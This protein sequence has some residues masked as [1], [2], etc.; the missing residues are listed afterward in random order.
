[1]RIPQ[2][3]SGE[4]GG[5]EAHVAGE[6]DPCP[7]AAVAPGVAL[8][9]EQREI[10]LLHRVRPQPD[11]QLDRQPARAVTVRAQRGV[12]LCALGR[13]VRI[14]ELG[15]GA[16]QREVGGVRG[17]RAVRGAVELQIAADDPAVRFR[18]VLRLRHGGWRE[19]RGRPQ[20]VVVLRVRADVR[21][22]LK[23]PP[24]ARGVHALVR[25]DRWV[26]ALDPER[27]IDDPNAVFP[28]ACHLGPV[29]VDDVKV[30]RAVRSAGGGERRLAQPGRVAPAAG[31]RGGVPARAGAGR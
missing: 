30:L 11:E 2:A 12:V 29:A 24:R 18:A 21:R 31:R 26:Q 1:M 19:P 28:S 27:L 9:L 15:V 25:L 14:S 20:R 17:P 10:P 7:R 4:R 3:V 6:V 16:L 13:A 23:P 22:V 8:A 5:R